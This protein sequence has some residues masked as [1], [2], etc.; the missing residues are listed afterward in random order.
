[1]VVAG[2]PDGLGDEGVDPDDEDVFV[3]GA[4]E[5]GG[6]SFCGSVRMDAPEKIVAELFG[7]GDFE[8]GDG[9]PWALR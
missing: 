6:G 9:V 1:M 8:A 4:V 3:V 5:E 2:L 7:S